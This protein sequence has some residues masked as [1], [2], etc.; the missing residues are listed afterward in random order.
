MK[1]LAK[2]PPPPA[3]KRRRRFTAERL[4]EAKDMQ[5]H[6]L[7]I[8]K[9]S[10]KLDW[11]QKGLT[12]ALAGLSQ[13]TTFSAMCGYCHRPKTDHTVLCKLKSPPPPGKANGKVVHVEPRRRERL[14]TCKY[15]E[16]NF[17][18]STGTA[19]VGHTRWHIRQREKE[20]VLP[21]DFWT[22]N[23]NL[24]KTGYTG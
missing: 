21:K 19:M 13:P 20:K 6:G 24:P 17:T 22:E 16:C 10:Q 9:I 12:R 14:Y 18:T 15:A 3:P 11:S 23:G 8:E 7:S 4:A 5:K 2:A 1:A